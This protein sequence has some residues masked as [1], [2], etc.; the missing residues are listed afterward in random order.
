MLL[1][2]LIP[3]LEERQAQLQE[4]L[5]KLEGQIQAEDGAGK[6]E[7]LHFLDNREH[8][9][10]HKRNSLLQQ[11]GGE[12]VVFLDDDDDV[13]ADYVALICRAI[14]EQPGI[15]CVGIQGIITFQ[16]LR[17][18]PF[19]QSFR[20][21]NWAKVGRVYQRPLLHTNPI[22]REI[23]QRHLF[24]DVSYSEDI[25]W[26]QRICTDHALRYEAMIDEPIYFYHSHRSWWYQVVID[27][28]EGIRR[29]LGL[30]LANR[31]RI[32]RWLRTRATPFR[33]WVGKRG[34]AH[35]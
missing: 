11:A 19:V 16:G 6:V 9:I 34:K 2:I 25:D 3:T 5:R 13:S 7:I 32:Q 15:D 8:S 31:L 22:R 14:R 24:E 20:H 30:Q 26:A 1:S 21:K 12:F 23:A 29:I 4:I 18:H 28:T 10:G 17:A 35:D 27:R 33:Q